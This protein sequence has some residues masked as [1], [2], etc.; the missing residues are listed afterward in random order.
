MF[1]SEGSEA[2]I[3][4]I[5]PCYVDDV[6]TIATFWVLSV[7]LIP[8][9]RSLSVN[10][11]SDATRHCTLGV[12]MSTKPNSCSS[13]DKS[14]TSFSDSVPLLPTNWYYHLDC[15]QKGWV[16][17]R[18]WHRRSFVY[19]RIMQKWGEGWLGV[20][21]RIHH[22]I[23]LSNGQVSKNWRLGIKGSWKHG[24]TINI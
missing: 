13:A 10:I 21:H 7:F 24:S 8:G 20:K 6:D 11:W 9:R 3:H 12:P 22:I 16:R 14:I 1:S 18:I 17:Y 15:L 19:D 4:N 5:V 23:S 2:A